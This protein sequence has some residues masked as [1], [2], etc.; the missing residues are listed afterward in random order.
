MSLRTFPVALTLVLGLI[1]SSLTAAPASGKASHAGWPR[2]DGVLWINKLDRARTKHGTHRSDELLGGH[3][4]DT[5]IG[6]RDADVIWGDYKPG[7]Q[8][9]SQVDRLWGG[10]GGDFI[11]ASHGYN[12]IHGGAGNDVIHAHFGRGI[13]DC[14]PGHDVVYLSHRGRRGWTLHGC[15]VVSYRTERQRGL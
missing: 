10:G 7:W 9:T 5:I 6:G 14:G 1:V 8:P 13:I 12:V 2:I 4:S 15:E 11:Y 3:G